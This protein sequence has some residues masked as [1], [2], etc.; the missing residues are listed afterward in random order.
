MELQFHKSVCHC[1]RQVKWETQDQEQTQEVK[2][3][4]AM[5]DIGRVLGAWG[6][7][8]LRTKEWRSGEMSVSGGVMV[9]TLYMPEDGSDPQSVE[10]WLPF[11]MKW[12]LPDTQRDGTILA[13]CLLHSVDARSISARKL[14]VRASVGILAE[15][16]VQEQMDI[17]V[18]SD[19]PEEVY[20]LKNS[21]PM[22]LPREAGEKPFELEEELILPSSCPPIGKILRYDADPQI[23]DKK[24]MATKLVFRGTAFV[25]ILYAS[26]GGELSSWD[27]E[28]PFSQYTEL[29][30]EYEPDAAAKIRLAV[31]SLETETDA[32]GKLRCKLGLTAQYIIQDRA[33]IEVA[34]D[35][36]S[37]SRDVAI[38][39]EDPE[40]PCVLENM[41]Q[42]VTAQQTAAAEGKS[43]A[44]I[45]FYPFQP[46]LH[47]GEEGVDME[48]GGQFKM[49]YYDE[50]GQLQSLAPMWEDTMRISADENADVQPFVTAEARPQASIGGGSAQLRAGVTADSVTFSGR[51]IPMITA[52]ELG[53]ERPADP[54]RP[55]LCLRR[56]EGE[57]LW[58][59]AKQS[60]SSVE[61]IRK[62]NG[63][64]QEP[65]EA[66]ILLIP[67]N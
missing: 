41:A 45:A 48:L 67:V 9:W 6:Q 27:F 24:V 56:A 11:Q 43:I 51:G 8:I 33:V 22:L 53:E 37:N 29:T 20:I 60:G 64:T 44:D 31:T 38:R 14:M 26:E 21:Y 34:E 65:D 25:H 5:P 50:N 59:I 30:Q 10:A 3:G 52:L 66:Q 55:S 63:L 15:A 18:P 61:A 57:S 23:V 62:A 32:E 46:R 1:L 19:I 42:S 7:V 58:E 36:Y 12:T 54:D 47:R 49:L 39:K 28:M 40:L 13:S 17:S 16:V 35:A 2:L 4:E